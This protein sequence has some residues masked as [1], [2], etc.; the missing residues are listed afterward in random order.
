MAPSSFFLLIA[1]PA[2]GA[3]GAVVSEAQPAAILLVPI[4]EGLA[5][6]GEIVVLNHGG[7]HPRLLLHVEGGLLLLLVVDLHIGE[8][9]VW[10]AGVRRVVSLR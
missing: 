4:T 5:A 9:I 1:T 8:E 6:K 2:I 3:G 7:H 10:L